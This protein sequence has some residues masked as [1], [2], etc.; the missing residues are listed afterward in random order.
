LEYQENAAREGWRLVVDPACPASFLEGLGQLGFEDALL[1]AGEKI[2]PD[3][4]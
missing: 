2:L 1:M 4:V 3:L